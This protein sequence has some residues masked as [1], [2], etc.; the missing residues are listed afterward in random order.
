MFCIPNFMDSIAVCIH[1]PESKHIFPIQL[2]VKD[3]RGIYPSTYCLFQL[4]I[5]QESQIQHVKLISLSASSP[6]SLLQNVFN[7]G[8]YLIQALIVYFLQQSNSHLNSLFDSQ[9][10][11]LNSVGLDLYWKHT[12]LSLMRV[13]NTLL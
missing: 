2:S 5:S 1:S 10:I 11:S 7:L 8:P 4:Q 9:C 3:T 12:T 6:V 13:K